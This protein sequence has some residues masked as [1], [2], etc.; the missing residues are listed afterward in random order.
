[1]DWNDLRYL[2]AIARG[3]T[4]AGAARLLG[5]E[6]STV[7]RRLS[8]L[9]TALK[10]RLFTRGPEGFT[11]TRAGTDILP[12]AEAVEAHIETIS[13]R[14]S[15]EDARVEGLVKLT[16]SESLSGYLVK[17]LSTLRERY[18]SLVVEIL[19][20]NRSFDLMRGEA[21][22]AVRIRAVTE[23]DLVARHLAVAGW[24]LYAAATYVER[25]GTPPSPEDLRGH[26]VIGFDQTLAQVPGALWL[27]EHGGSA[28]V[29]LR[30]NSIIA[31]FNAALVGLGATV[32]P[33]FLGDPEP[34]LRRLTPRVLGEREIMLVVHPDLARVARVRAVMDFLV[35]VFDRDRVLWRGAPAT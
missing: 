20:G 32:L 21:D 1:V 11:L 7:G 23:P 30:G 2:L 25:K 3:R 5:V 12:L 28:N 22:L 10:T 8:A 16:T 15:G 24:S 34:T 6:H 31:V 13:R 19:S 18:P 9:E 4:L 29:V 35:E 33:C 26:D 14:V 27:A 17:Q